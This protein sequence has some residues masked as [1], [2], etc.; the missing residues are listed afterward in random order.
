LVIAYYVLTLRRA[1]MRIKLTPAFVTAATAAAGQDKTFFWDERMPNFGLVVYESGKK[2]C[3][4][5][6][7][8]RHRSHRKAIAGV[9]SLEA[10]R[11]RARKLLG[12][13][14]DGRDPLGEERKKRDAEKNTLR[15]ISLEF[16]SREG[17][18]L[19]SAEEWLKSLERA[20]FPILGSRPIAD[21]RRSDVVR[22][23]DK[24]EDERGPAAAQTSFAILRR[25]MSWH[26][27]RSDDFRS[28]IVRGMSRRRSKENARARILTDEE[29]RAVWKATSIPRIHPVPAADGG[30]AERG[31]AHGAER[32]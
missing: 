28:P 4:V 8:H 25:V 7:R 17:K 24:I 6:Y 16:F 32:D 5:Q 19:R 22:L 3:C 15:A 9:L 14:A 21:I 10:A 1:Q 12:Q 11:K 26:S 23:L 2:G 30:Q 29:L 20:A 18:H 27:A 31:R 13:V